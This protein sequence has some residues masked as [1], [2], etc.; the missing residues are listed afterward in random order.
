M[1]EQVKNGIHSPPNTFWML[2]R[3]K[4]TASGKFGER[5]IGSCGK[6]NPK[7][8]VTDLNIRHSGGHRALNSGG[9]SRTHRNYL[10][11]IK[12]YVK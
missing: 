2:E 3:E 10:Q 12:V 8:I 5:R 11:A 6:S 7:M 1:L 4:V 9:I